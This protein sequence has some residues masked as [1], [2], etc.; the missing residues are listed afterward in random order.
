MHRDRL[1]LAY[2]SAPDDLIDSAAK[3]LAMADLFSAWIAEA[4]VV[5][6]GPGGLPIVSDATRELRRLLNDHENAIERLMAHEADP[7]R[8][9]YAYVKRLQEGS[10]DAS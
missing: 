5:R 3:R 8:D 6:R 9:A 7:V 10:T 2:P 4:G 1:R